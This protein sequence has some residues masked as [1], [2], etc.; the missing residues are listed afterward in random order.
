[1]FRTRRPQDAIKTSASKPNRIRDLSC[2]TSLRTWAF[3]D[4][5]PFASPIA[6]PVTLDEDHAWIIGLRSR[7]RFATAITVV[8][9]ATFA[10]GGGGGRPAAAAGAEDQILKAPRARARARARARGKLFAA[11]DYR[12]ALEIYVKLYAET[13]HPTYLRNIGRCQQNLGEAEKAISSFREYL[14]KAKDLTPSS[15]R[16]SKGTSPRWRS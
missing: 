6:F 16:R 11:G 9:A 7:L 13:L 10:V 3:A 1:M 8:L 15:A 2:M 14:R 12:Q 4:G 5:T